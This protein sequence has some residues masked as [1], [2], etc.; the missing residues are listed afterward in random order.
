MAVN[1]II[2]CVSGDLVPKYFHGLESSMVYTVPPF[3]V[4][5]LPGRLNRC[6]PSLP[7]HMDAE[8]IVP[9]F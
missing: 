5:S 4:E 8:E 7:L 1:P 9:A 3:F 6:L 2:E